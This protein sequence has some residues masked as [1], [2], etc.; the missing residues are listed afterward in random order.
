MTCPFAE[1]FAVCTDAFD[2]TYLELTVNQGSLEVTAYNHNETTG[3]NTVLDQFS[4]ACDHSEFVHD[5]AARQ[6]LC[7][8]CGQVCTDTKLHRICTCEG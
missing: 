8:I 5:A 2:A 6:L 1:S 7:T 4:L 3:K